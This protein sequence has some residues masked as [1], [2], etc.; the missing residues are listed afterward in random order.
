MPLIQ[1]DLKGKKV[2]LTIELDRK[3]NAML[4][5]YVRFCRADTQKIVAGALR[6]LFEQDKEFVSWLEDRA[7]DGKKNPSSPVAEPASSL[8]A[9]DTR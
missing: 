3:T 4:K 8:T 9:S 5:K 2:S 6:R 7:H 1:S